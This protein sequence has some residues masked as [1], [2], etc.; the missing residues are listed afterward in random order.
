[1]VVPPE[2]L[3]S[4][5]WP[6]EEPPAA[7][8]RSAG[9]AGRRLG[10]GEDVGHGDLGRVVRGGADGRGHTSLLPVC[11]S[12][13]NSGHNHIQRQLNANVTGVTT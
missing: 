13:L 1:M 2:I 10:A 3:A 4:V 6:R 11:R 5:D 8:D 9:V 7:A 12:S